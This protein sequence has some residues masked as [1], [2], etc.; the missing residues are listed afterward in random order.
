[1]NAVTM[2]EPD[3]TKISQKMDP[4]PLAKTQRREAFL[5]ATA[6]QEIVKM[7]TECV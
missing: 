5:N 4:L 6:K 1:M 3:S 7:E 2:Y